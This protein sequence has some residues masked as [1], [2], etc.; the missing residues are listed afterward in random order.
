MTVYG[1]RERWSLTWI[2]FQRALYADAPFDAFAWVLRLGRAVLEYGYHW[3]GCNRAYPPTVPVIALCLIGLC[4]LSYFV[5]LREYIIHQ[6]WCN[7]NND[8]DQELDDDPPQCWSDWVHTIVVLYFGVMICWNHLQ[9]TFT[10]PGVALPNS[11]RNNTTIAAG[12]QQ[13][14]QQQQQQPKDWSCYASQGGCCG[15]HVRLDEREETDRVEL[16][17][18]DQ[19]NL[20]SMGIPSPTTTTPV[21]VSDV[22]VGPTFCQKCRIWRPPRCHHCSQCNRCVLQMDHHCP[23]VNNCIGYNN[24]RTFFLTLVYLTTGCLYGV[25]LLAVPFGEGLYDQVALHGWK[26]LYAN[27]TGFLDLP[28]PWKLIRQA[29][30]VG[31]GPTL[32]IKLVLPLMLGSGI[33]LGIFCGIHAHYIVTART[34]LEHKSMLVQLEAQAYQQLRQGGTGPR[35]PNHKRPKSPFDTGSTMGNIRQILGPNLWLCLLPIPVTPPP[36]FMPTKSD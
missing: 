11:S 7:S 35:R 3:T 1:Y 6:R 29:L 27:Q 20:E 13:H 15:W 12:Q 28:G 10:S 17:G 32:W 25:A 36:P 16:Y 30:T 23:W 22:A 21:G 19:T 2:D 18:T 9:T 8:D 26:F 31:L 33:T 4:I 24:Y 14:Q 5:S 34:N